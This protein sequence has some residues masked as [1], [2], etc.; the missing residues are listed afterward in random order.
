MHRELRAAL[1]PPAPIGRRMLRGVRAAPRALAA[2]DCGPVSVFGEPFEAL[3]VAILD[4]AQQ[5]NSVR[6]H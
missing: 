5:E 6:L 2:I 4:A 1:A 3:R